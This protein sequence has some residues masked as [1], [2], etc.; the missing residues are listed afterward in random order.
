MQTIDRHYIDGRWVPSTGTERHT[1]FNPATEQAYGEVHL[2]SEADADAAAAAA[3]RTAT[4]F[5]MTTRAERLALLGAIAESFNKHMPTLIDT[6]QQSLGAPRVLC[7]R[8]QVP[9]GLMQ[10]QKWSQLLANFVFEE[11]RGQHRVIHH[12]IGPSLCI[13]SWNYPINGPMGVILP[14]FAAGCP[15]VW[16]PSEQTAASAELLAQVMHDSGVPAGA[17]NMVHGHG[18]SVG[19]RLVVDPAIQMVSFTGSLHTGLQVGQAAMGQCKRLVLELGG[20]SAFIVLP[21]A[22]LK[23]AVIGCVSGLM[24][25]T[26][27]SCNAPSRLLVPKSQLAA[28]GQIAAAVANGLKVGD[29]AD[30][31]TQ[32]GPL[33]NAQQF[34]Q[35]QS[36]I[37]HGIDSGATLLTGGT[38][39][40]TNLERGWYTKPTIFGDVDPDSHVAQEEVFGP[41]LALIGYDD[42]DQAVEIA[43]RSPYGLSAYV[44]G[45]QALDVAPRLRAG[46][47]HVNGAEMDIGMPFGGFKRSGLGRKFGPEGLHHYLETQS[48]LIP[49]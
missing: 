44:V 30:P 16:K 25:N 40:P 49:A 24:R 14:A 48:I 27:Q 12:S 23:A 15:V 18:G 35:V 5:A 31:A 46:M 45:A 36:F 8:L 32:V 33:G 34:S 17:F 7:E 6:V 3:E 11:T 47:V 22:D 19:R 26:G 39:R 37:Q 9:A 4:N 1:L 28:A 10:L 29:P 2:G 20:K 13:T 38:G 43:N 21:D 42:V 41:V